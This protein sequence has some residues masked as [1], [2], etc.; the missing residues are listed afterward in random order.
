MIDKILKKSG[1]KQKSFPAPKASFRDISELSVAL[2]TFGIPEIPYEYMDFLMK[3]ANGLSWNGVEFFGLEPVDFPEDQYTLPGLEEFNHTL[4]YDDEFD[5][6]L[7]IGRADEEYYAWNDYEEVY[8]VV[9]RSGKDALLTFSSFTG[10][11]AEALGVRDIKGLN[12][13]QTSPDL[14]ETKELA[15]IIK[16]L[17][18][19]RMLIITPPTQK[20]QQIDEVNRALKEMELPPLPASYCSFL[21]Q[22]AGGMIWQE[23]CFYGV[24]RKRESHDLEEPELPE[25]L[26][27][28]K[29]WK[30]ERNLNNRLLLGL[31]NQDLFLYNQKTGNFETFCQLDMQTMSSFP[32]FLDLVKDVVYN[33]QKMPHPSFA[34]EED[35]STAIE[36]T[37]ETK[38]EKT[39]QEKWERPDDLRCKQL[40]A[41]I[42]QQH[43]YDL[44]SDVS[45]QIK[46]KRISFY[47]DYHL[48]EATNFGSIPPMTMQYFVKESLVVK[49]DGTREPFDTMNKSGSLILNAETVKDYARF[50]LSKI[51]AEEGPFRIVEDITEVNFS[52]EPTREEFIR[53]R[54]VIRPMKVESLSGSYM[55]CAIVLYSDNV[56]KTL[57][58]VSPDGELDIEEETTLLTDMPV[59]HIMLR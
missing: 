3:N 25:I 56:Y 47:P 53:I 52:R 28:N 7:V 11:L 5:D 38:Q 8:E 44:F 34:P 18:V 9:C 46:L 51:Y 16:S 12:I 50:V 6:R 37:L 26:R 59:R 40:I 39:V 15:A 21:T 33:P 14:Q 49:L 43:G 27:Y 41:I 58:K 10:L 29:A 19:A 35:A 48:M 42:N 54:N 45:T 57:L 17:K 32:T 22:V 36:S 24:A 4:L 2:S 31:D 1:V 20:L 13:T 30:G 23:G 55:L